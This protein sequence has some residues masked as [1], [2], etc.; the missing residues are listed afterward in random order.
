MARELRKLEKA[1]NLE[2]HSW[3][4]IEFC[5]SSDHYPNHSSCSNFVGIGSSPNGRGIIHNELFNS[6]KIDSLKGYSSGD[7]VDLIG[8]EDP[9]DEGGDT[10]VSVSLGEIFLEGKKSWESDI[11]DSDN[12]GDGGKTTGRAIIT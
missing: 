11:G 7:I 8:D 9:T 3:P 6:A 10:E 12:I 2:D 5:V 1:H 4:L